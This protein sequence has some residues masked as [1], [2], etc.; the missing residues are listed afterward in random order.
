VD[1]FAKQEQ[2]R[3]ERIASVHSDY[4]QDS[5]AEFPVKLRI[6]EYGRCI[7]S[8]SVVAPTANHAKAICEKFESQASQIYAGL[9]STLT[10][11]E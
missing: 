11:D 4:S 9:I 10:A 7:F 1:N 2:T 8:M 5:D 6:E 3:N